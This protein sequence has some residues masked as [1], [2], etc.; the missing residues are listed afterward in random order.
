MPEEAL[1]I[2][3][4]I[5]AELQTNNSLLLA[6]TN[7]LFLWAGIESP[8]RFGILDASC[9]LKCFFCFVFL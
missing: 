7:H 5:W 4:I 1:T 6:N 9:I 8:I 3:L 2:D